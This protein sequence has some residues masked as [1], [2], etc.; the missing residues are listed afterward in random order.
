MTKI[1]YTLIFT[2]GSFLLTAQDA[3]QPA[4]QLDNIAFAKLHSQIDQ[5]ANKYEQQVVDWRRHYHENPELSNREFKTGEH[6]ADLLEGMGLEVTRKVAK[7]G[8]KAVLR[9][10]KPGPVIA[11]RA[12]IDALPVV[13][14]VDIPFASKV[15]KLTKA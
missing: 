6:I 5:L 4:T 14:R 3:L 7:T 1:I 12:D 13:E 10:G 2:M 15:K 8:V 11:L 9:T